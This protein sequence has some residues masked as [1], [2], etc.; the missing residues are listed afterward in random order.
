MRE[1]FP[2]QIELAWVFVGWVRVGQIGRVGR[3]FR[4]EGTV[5]ANTETDGI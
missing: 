4:R 3:A 2:E 5:C 1:H